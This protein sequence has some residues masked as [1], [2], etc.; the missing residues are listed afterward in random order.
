MFKFFLFQRHVSEL[1]ITDVTIHANVQ[2]SQNIWHF[3]SIV[4]WMIDRPVARGVISPPVFGR[5]VNPISTRGGHIMPTTLLRA[6]P[7]FKTLR[8]P[9]ILK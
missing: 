2:T 7:D 6:T 3:I 9:C 1:H 8:R 5:S 4:L